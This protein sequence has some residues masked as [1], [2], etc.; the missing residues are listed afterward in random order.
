MLV[1]ANSTT[2]ATTQ[3][4]LIRAGL[5]KNPDKLL[6]KLRFPLWKISIREQKHRLSMCMAAR[7]STK[8]AYKNKAFA[9]FTYFGKSYA[10]LSSG[11]AILESAEGVMDSDVKQIPNDE[12]FWIGL[13]ETNLRLGWEKCLVPRENLEAETAT[14]LADRLKVHLDVTDEGY[15]FRKDVMWFRPKPEAGRSKTTGST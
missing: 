6:K 3:T 4:R 14:I 13:V 1:V 7:P 5:G 2:W 12:A 11:I 15:I 9:R 8:K 10:F